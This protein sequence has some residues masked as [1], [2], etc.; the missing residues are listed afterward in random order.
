MVASS[1]A[2]LSSN[3]SDVLPTATILGARNRNRLLPISTSWSAKVGQARLW[4]RPLFG[5]EEAAA[6]PPDPPDAARDTPAPQPAAVSPLGP[7]PLHQPPSSGIFCP[8]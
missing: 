7:P 5:R 1:R 2:A 3:R 6:T 8:P 4:S